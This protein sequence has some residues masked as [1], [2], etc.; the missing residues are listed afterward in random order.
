VSRPSRRV[1][2]STDSVDRRD[3]FDLWREVVGRLYLGMDVRPLAAV[4]HFSGRVSTMTAGSVHVARVSARPTPHVGVRTP[5]A[6]AR[7]GEHCFLIGMTLAGTGTLVQ[8]DRTAV[9][10]PGDFAMYDS[11]RPCVLH[12]EG[13]LEML[14]LQIPWMTMVAALPGAAAAT[15]TVINGRRGSAALIRPLLEDLLATAD[16]AA[17]AAQRHCAAAAVELIA[18]SL[19]EI[20]SLPA[21]APL[22][23]ATLARA[24]QYIEQ[25]LWDPDLSPADVARAVFVSPRHLQAIFHEQQTSVARFVMQRRLE[26]AHHDLADPRQAHL[27]VA[28]IAARL[29]FRRPSHFAHVFRTRFGLSPREHRHASR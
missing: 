5:A 14:T 6:I 9:V 13:D 19:T 3:R 11:T 24:Q 18:A 28:D 26:R 7:D 25:H 23:A 1:L 8:G 17:P 20:A 29:G 15:A 22:R 27:S 10:R 4:E 12:I 21:G 16:G 2:L